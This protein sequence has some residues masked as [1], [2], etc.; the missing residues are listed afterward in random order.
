[1]EKHNDLDAY[2]GVFKRLDNVK[3]PESYQ[4]ETLARLNETLDEV[5][6]KANRR[7]WVLKS[8]AFSAIVLVT[9]GTSYVWYQSDMNSFDYGGQQAANEAEGTTASEGGENAN[10]DQVQGAANSSSDDEGFTFGYILTGESDNWSVQLE[11]KNGKAVPWIKKNEPY[12]PDTVYEIKH[13]FEIT[14]SYIGKPAV[15]KSEIN[16]GVISIGNAGHIFDRN[17]TTG[18]VGIEEISSGVYKLSGRMDFWEG[19]KHEVLDQILG[20]SYL[21]IEW[22]GTEEREIIQ[23]E[24]VSD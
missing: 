19:T 10:G 4:I 23:L 14:F 13:E 3:L 1:M 11:V 22:N 6:Q 20:S 7:P 9:V 15:S 21:E 17:P 16:R 12:W 8:L 2:D 5:D 18:I 24:L